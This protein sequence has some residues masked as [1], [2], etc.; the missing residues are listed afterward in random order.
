MLGDQAAAGKVSF[1]RGELD[2]D[3]SGILGPGQ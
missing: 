1:R 3:K 2:S